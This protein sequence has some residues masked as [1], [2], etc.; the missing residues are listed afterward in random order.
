MQL[1]FLKTLLAVTWQ[2]ITEETLKCDINE[3]TL[4]NDNNELDKEFDVHF[5]ELVANLG[6]N[7]V[8]ED[9]VNFDAK[10]CST[11]GNQFRYSGGSWWKLLLM[12]IVVFAK[13]MKK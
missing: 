11:C 13:I 4:E 10:T 5:I 7:I 2:E 12:N 6:S 8:V 9:Y 1:I 3:Q